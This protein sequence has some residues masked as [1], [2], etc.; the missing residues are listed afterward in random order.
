MIQL[1]KSNTSFFIPYFLFL[2]TG[3]VSL[4]YFNKI[5][6]QLFINSYH[7]SFGDIFFKYWTCLGLGE[8]I[9]PV[10]LLLAFIRKRYLIM[11]LITYLLTI[12]INDSIKFT[13]GA[14]RP[15][16]AIFGIAGKLHLVQGVDVYTANSFPSG[17]AAVGFGV[18]CLLSLISSA[19]LLKLIF[20]ITAFLVAYSR[21]Y[22]SEHF[23]LDVYSGSIIGVSVSVFTYYYLLNLPWL[24]K[25]KSIDKPLLNLHI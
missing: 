7:S 24:N 17:H 4:L 14:P 10:A 23:L 9:I 2:F 18:Y 16:A 19:Q 3:G 6:I 11:V 25:F 20:F 5:E 21:V 12:L 15:E 8:I 22:L 1:F 13:V